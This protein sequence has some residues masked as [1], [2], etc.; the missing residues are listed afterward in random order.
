MPGRVNQGCPYR[1]QVEALAHDRLPEGDQSRVQEH[2][3][4]CT[5]CRTAY[6][7]LTQ[8][9]FPRLRNYTVV[10]RVGEG[11]FGVVYKV[12][13]HDKGRTEALKVLFS[14]TP[15]RAAY[16]ENEVRLVA[17]L[18]HPNIATLYDAHLGTAP[19]YYTMEFVAGVQL[20][21]YLRRRLVSLEERIRLVRQVAAAVGYAH[22]QGVVHRD[23]KPQNILVDAS[24]QPRIV[25]F[26]IA[27]RLE[28]ERRAD[29]LPA[30]TPEGVVG[31]FGYVAPE[32]LAGEPIDARADVF[33]LGAL[34]FHTLTGLPASVDDRPGRLLA[35]LDS[36][37]VSRSADLA[38][39]VA[40]CVAADPSLRYATCD[41]L[42][43]DLDSYLAGRP[44][45]ACS[46]QG[47]GY[48]MARVSLLLLRNHP[49]AVR[50][51]LVVAGVSLLSLV[52]FGIG[53]GWLEAGEHP[54]GVALVAFAPSTLAALGAGQLSDP[55]DGVTVADRKSW[56][57]LHGRLMQRL[58][59]SGARVVA[60]DYFF[61]DSRPEFDAS[62]IAGAHALQDRGTPVVV[63]V[64]GFH[65]DGTP[66]ICPEIRDGVAAWGVLMSSK[67]TDFTQELKPVHAFQRGFDDPV[68]SLPLAAFTAARH[69]DCT[70]HLRFD[71]NALEVRYR[72]RNFTPDEPSWLRQ[73]DRIPVQHVREI[74]QAQATLKAGD[75]VAHGRVLKEGLQNWGNEFVPYEDVLRADP[76]ALRRWFENR[77]LV[78]GQMLP[79]MDEYEADDGSTV[80]GC[81]THAQVLQSLLRGGLIRPFTR[82]QLLFRTAGWCVLAVVL[83]TTACGRSR[84]AFGHVVVVCGALSALGLVLAVW[85]AVFVTAAWLA[86]LDILLS[87]VLLVGPPAYLIQWLRLRQIR[88]AP[89]D[90]WSSDD[91]TVTTTRLARG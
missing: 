64:A 14:R 53:A 60:W 13:H 78:I 82:A 59:E 61:P 91:S 75:R 3:T 15:K 23:L 1:D 71:R 17:R 81:Q 89:Y 32:Q 16:F 72:R 18:R 43:E 44:I 10:E 77:A 73:R 49:L 4:A 67:P 21:E 69:P 47:P 87:A 65:A 84:A 35:F 41:E 90:G 28:F 5:P 36:R 24:G 50:A 79:G 76:P 58:S 26:G 6:R 22:A 63:G 7:R 45:R 19:L 51:A 74:Q 29:S 20:N 52:F 46:G 57:I 37:D 12:V 85:S 39:I 33:A 56:R 40:R 86:E 30:T 31:T 27:K 62:F 88:L 9:W 83:A 54:G 48:W 38:A 2:L 68:P 70:A 66:V 25:D 11:G 80:F 55:T 34:L 8:G 42:V